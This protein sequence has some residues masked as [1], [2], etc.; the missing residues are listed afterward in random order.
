MTGTLCRA[1]FWLPLIALCAV[2]VSFATAA[3]ARTA[4]APLKIKPVS[5][6]TTFTTAKFTVPTSTATTLNIGTGT[7]K[8][9]L[10]GTPEN[11]FKTK[12]VVTVRGLSPNT[13]YYALITVKNKAGKSAKVWKTFKTAAPG[14]APATVTSNGN[15]LLLNGQPFFGILTDAYNNPCPDNNTTQGSA[16]LG[17]FIFDAEDDQ[18]FNCADGNPSDWGNSLNASLSGKAWWLERNAEAAQQLQSQGLTELLNWQATSERIESP[19]SRVYENPC[20]S[21]TQLFKV[22]SKDP[23]AA[24]F[25]QSLSTYPI[26]PGRTTCTTPANLS[27][28]FWTLVAGGGAGIEYVTKDQSGQFDVSGELQTQ[29]AKLSKELAALGPAVLAGKKLTFGVSSST[30]VREGGW[31][32]GGVVYIVAVNTE[33][34]PAS[35]SFSMAGVGATAKA[36]QVMWEGRST[37]VVGGKIVDNFGPYAVHIYKVIPVIRNK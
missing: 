1:R 24:I 32:Y 16:S 37:K 34:Q 6:V 25:Y 33:P 17:A 35:D 18:Q 10:V 5:V 30:A 15:K 29:A 13:N 31:Q 27:M 4:A 7:D 8:T 3:Q 12:H 21:S 14:S 20:S 22:V 9:Y 11:R 2:V 28:A 36:A 23:K 19:S 26:S